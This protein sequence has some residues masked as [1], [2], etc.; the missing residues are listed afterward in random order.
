MS[1][2][3]YRIWVALAIH[4]L[5]CLSV[6][7]GENSIVFFVALLPVTLNIAGIVLM[8]SKKVKAGCT[9]FLIGSALFVPIGLIG[10]FGARKM[11]DKLKEEDFY[12]TN[13]DTEHGTH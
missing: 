8:F 2:I 5:I 12:T 10:V 13:N 11:M 1:K 3:D 9:L 6:L 7:E 4:L